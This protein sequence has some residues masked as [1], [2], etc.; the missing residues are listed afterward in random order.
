MYT[1]LGYVHNDMIMHTRSE[2]M[3]KSIANYRIFVLLKCI[4][5]NGKKQ[6]RRPKLSNN[7]VILPDEV[8]EVSE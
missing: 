1:S 7:E 6:L 4:T 3:S 5:L 8:E 2:A